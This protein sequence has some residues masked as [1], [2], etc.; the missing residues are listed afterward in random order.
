MKIKIKFGSVWRF[1]VPGT[2]HILKSVSFQ[3]IRTH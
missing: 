1:H 3:M 2:E